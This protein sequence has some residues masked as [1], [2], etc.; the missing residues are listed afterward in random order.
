MIFYFSLALDGYDWHDYSACLE[1][2][3]AFEGWALF[4]FGFLVGPAGK[5][6]LLILY[7]AFGPDSIDW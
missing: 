6:C 3:T 4:N 2:S 5:P 1:A 7:A